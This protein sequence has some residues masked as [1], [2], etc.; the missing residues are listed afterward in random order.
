[1]KYDMME[2]YKF[3]GPCSAV[4]SSVYNSRGIGS[5]VLASVFFPYINYWKCNFSMNPHVGLLIGWYVRLL[6]GP[7]DFHNF[8]KGHEITLP[9]S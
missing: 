5:S 1:M 2:F 6:F 7:C 9:C 8:L 3:L 4:F